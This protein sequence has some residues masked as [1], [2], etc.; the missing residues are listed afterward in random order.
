MGKSARNQQ[1]STI[2]IHHTISRQIRRIR[3]LYTLALV[4]TGVAVAFIVLYA[5]KEQQSSRR[6]ECLQSNCVQVAAGVISRMNTTTNPCEDFYQYSCGG[7]LDK[8]AIPDSKTRYS[9]FSEVSSRNREI[10]KLEISKIMS[11]QKNSS[12]VWPVDQNVWP[13]D[14]NVWPVDQNVWPVDQNVWPVDQNV[15]PVD[16][17]V[18]PVDQNV[19][20]VDQNVWPVDQNVWPVDQIGIRISRCEGVLEELLITCFGHL[21]CVRWFVQ[22]NAFLDQWRVVG[23]P[24]LL[25][26]SSNVASKSLYVFGPLCPQWRTVENVWPVDQNVWPVDQNVWPVDQNVWPVDQNVWP[27]DQNVWPVDQNVW[28]VDQNV[29]PVDQNVW[30][31]DQNVWPVDQIGIRI[32]RCE[33]VLEELLITCFG[34]LYCV[35]WF[36]Q[37]NAFLDQ[38]RVVGSPDLL[39]R[40]SNVASK[41]LYVFGPLCPQWRTV[42]SMSIRNAVD[43]YSSCLDKKSIEARGDQPLK[44]VIKQYNSWPVTDMNFTAGNWNWTDTFIRVHKYLAMAPVFNMYVGSDLK[45]S[46]VNVITLDQSGLGISREAYLRNTTYHKKVSSAYRTLMRKLVTLLGAN[47]NG[48]LLMDKVYEFEKRLANI[49]LPTE[50]ARQYNKNYQKM[51]LKDFANKTG[52]PLDWLKNWL[53]WAF[54]ETGHRISENEEVVT[55]SLD[56]IRDS[57]KLFK[58]EDPFV[59]SSYIMWKVVFSLGSVLLGKYKEAYNDYY[60]TIYGTTA[61]D[62]RWETCISSTTS[63]FGFALGRLFVDK[64]FIGSAKTMAEEMIQGIRKS[65][66]ENIDTLSWMDDAT[67]KAAKEKAVAI[68]QNIGYPDFVV[69]DSD[70]DKYYQGLVVR[71]GNFFAN[72]VSRRKFNNIRN[73]VKFGKPVDKSLWAMT[74]A[75]V[76]AYYSP[77]ENKIVFP[78]GILQTPFYDHRAPRALNYGAI[79]VVVGHEI[80]HGF[81]DQGKT[82]NK[83]GNSENWWTQKSEQGF[84]NQAKCLV[85]QYSKYSMYGKNLNGNQ[86]LGENI[87]DNGGS[88][89]AFK[90]YQEWVKANG[91]EKRLPGIDLSP[92][93]LFFVGFAQVWCS[94]YRE[95]AAISQIENG[96]HSISKFRIIGT[97]H[98][99]DD[100]ARVFKCPSKSFMNP[101]TKCS[102]W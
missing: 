72:I 86:T 99:S 101:S 74:P 75:Q 9:I 96:V 87:A 1:Y 63:A 38:W 59:Q 90:A 10:I 22:Q 76:N 24:D 88:K 46:S 61:E 13:V 14:Q 56:Y 48:T 17:N 15:W 102:V 41:S 71:K 97:L 84:K 50:Q 78:A 54:L 37:Q 32:S 95:S 45:N 16:Q 34:H 40:S 43:Y 23:S 3:C 100:F 7:W 4:S 26:R 85:D 39:K 28:P 83:D 18:W 81:D 64:A 60:S 77:T 57:Y 68:I 62:P 79:G 92:E 36:V 44:D 98:N 33:G 8:T 11:G 89:A 20:P 73:Y 29:W 58:E 12:N 52:I 42:E 67:K 80:T 65:F 27:V 49:T 94:K 21:Y 66:M 82:F 35:R 30:P 47:K 69:K 53:D 5:V 70:L 55:Y 93:Q 91:E 19:W 25:K 31:V 2:R 6:K 51:K